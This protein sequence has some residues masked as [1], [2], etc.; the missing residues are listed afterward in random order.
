[1]KGMIVIFA[2]IN[3]ILSLLIYVAVLKAWVE[4]LR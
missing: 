3:F 4:T 1:M 2:A